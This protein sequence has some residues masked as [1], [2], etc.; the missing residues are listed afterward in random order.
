MNV[1]YNIKKAIMFVG[2]VK[3]FSKY[4]YEYKSSINSVHECRFWIEDPVDEYRIVRFG[5]EEDNLSMVLN[6]L[7]FDDV[8]F[9]IGS[10]IG[11]YSIYAAKVC[12]NVIAFEPDNDI[13]GRL[14]KSIKLNN[15]ANVQVIDWA[16]SNK[17]EKTISIPMV[18]VDFLP[19]YWI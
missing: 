2:N 6:N 10:N 15:L 13:R 3:F 12:K 8:F 4:P 5:D 11:L 16:V 1:L 14:V 9:D 18:Q 19:R 7:T 17:N